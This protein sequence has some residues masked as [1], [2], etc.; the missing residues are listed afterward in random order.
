MRWDPDGESDDGG[1]CCDADHHVEFAEFVGG[2]TWNDAA[3]YAGT[4]EDRVS[5]VT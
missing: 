3:K 1:K 2:N 4:K 5:T